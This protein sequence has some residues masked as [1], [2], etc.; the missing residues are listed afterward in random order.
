MEESNRFNARVSMFWP[1]SNYGSIT[2]NLIISV[3]GA[4]YQHGLRYEILLDVD[5]MSSRLDALNN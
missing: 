4:K 1:I 3:E 5:Q 2:W